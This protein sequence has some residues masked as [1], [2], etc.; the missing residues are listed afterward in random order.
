MHAYRVFLLSP[1][2]AAQS[3]LS[4]AVL[5]LCSCSSTRLV[6]S[7]AAIFVTFKAA[8]GLSAE[9]WVMLCLGLSGMAC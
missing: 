7:K 1:F 8:Q 5:P 9:R 4:C 2:P 3:F 6:H